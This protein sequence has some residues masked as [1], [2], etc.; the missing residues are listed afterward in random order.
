MPLGYKR[1]AASLAGETPRNLR[2]KSAPR[3]EAEQRCEVIC[4]A[5]RN[6]PGVPEAAK[7]LLTAALPPCLAVNK[8]K[9]HA[10]QHEMISMAD[11][12]LAA[13]Q[14]ELET[15]VANADAKLA[16]S[17]AEKQ[18]RDLA[19]SEAKTKVEAA[20]AVAAQTLTAKT[21]AKQFEETKQAALAEA[22]KQEQASIAQLEKVSAEKTSLESVES[23]QLEPLKTAGGGKRAINALA[24][25]LGAFGG[26]DQS[27]LQAMSTTLAKPADQHTPF[28]QLALKQLEESLS[29]AKGKVDVE[30]ETLDAAKTEQIKAKDAAQEA[31]N[32]AKEDHDN[33]HNVHEEA[34]KAGLTAK[35][36]LQQAEDAQNSFD[37]DMR[38]IA[39]SMDEANKSLATFKSGPLESF[40]SLRDTE[41]P[42]EPPVELALPIEIPAAAKDGAAEVA[43]TAAEDGAVE[44]AAE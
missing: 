36:A 41:T 6:T 11:A 15:A 31:Y 2:R 8:D 23:T 35:E 37:A 21:E 38:E 14:K 5:L 4:T 42:A 44:A 10:F 24:K 28:D 3:S 9:R 32:K 22:L 7:D 30:L 16:D 43:P 29:C 33:A 12:A 17:S 27:L 18:R 13:F 25:A 20:D 26:F 19:A 34:V 39:S 1:P 40:T